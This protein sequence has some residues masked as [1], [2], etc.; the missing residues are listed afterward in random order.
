MWEYLVEV[1]KWSR[2]GYP[3]ANKTTMS[4]MRVT[5]L[6][7]A[8]K[9]DQ[10]LHNLLIMKRR[11]TPVEE[12]Y[13]TLKDIVLQQ[14]NERK[15]ET[16]YR[17]GIS[18]APGRTESRW[19]GSERWRKSE[20]EDQLSDGE[21]SQKSVDQRGSI[22]C[23]NCGGVGHIVKQ[24]TSKI[25]GNVGRED[26]LEGTRSSMVK[27][28]ENCEILGQKR[29]VTIDSGSVVS[30]I[31]SGAWEKLKRGCIDW[32]E[33]C[34]V[35]GKPY[36]KLLDA[37]RRAMPVREQVKM[38]IKMNGKKSVIVFQIV[39]N[40][41]DNFLIGANAFKAVGIEL[42]WK[43]KQAVT[44]RASGYGNCSGVH[45]NIWRM[46]RTNVQTNADA[47]AAKGSRVRMERG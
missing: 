47:S 17:G 18:D 13:D 34:E 30:V 8:A 20:K 32:K 12:Q 36:F 22:K 14:E 16:V 31:S 6:M 46:E 3:E 37:S 15:K 23:Y 38:E 40:N 7:K 33:R 41:A 44:Q 25:V 24:C 42:R 4:Q 11:E 2:K 27:M 5:K 26:Q 35:L 29:K 19:N 1:E 39:R 28:W 21:A 45:R 9:D 10:N 43:A